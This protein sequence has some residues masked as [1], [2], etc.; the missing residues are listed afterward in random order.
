MATTIDVDLDVADDS[1]AHNDRR[2]QCVVAK[3]KQLVAPTEPQPLGQR[4]LI[5]SF[6]RRERK[7]Q[8]M[9]GC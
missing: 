6:F 7:E 1:R 3:R 2:R 5:L 9:A 8:N 4:V